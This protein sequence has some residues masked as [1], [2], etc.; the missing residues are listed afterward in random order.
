LRQDKAARAAN[1]IL[2]ITKGIAVVG[3]PIRK[4]GSWLTVR[5]KVDP[6]AARII[7]D[8]SHRRRDFEPDPAEKGRGNCKF[9]NSSHGT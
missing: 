2:R 8:L 9:C 5:W 7:V 4:K 1:A 6:G 3:A